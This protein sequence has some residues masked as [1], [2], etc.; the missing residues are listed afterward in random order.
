MCKCV[1]I[2]DYLGLHISPSSELARSPESLIGEPMPKTDGTVHYEHH[3]FHK[4]RM[5][6]RSR[7]RVLLELH[8]RLPNCKLP[9]PLKS[10]DLSLEEHLELC[11]AVGP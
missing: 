11:K 5:S 6:P 2:G 7:V 9:A 8:G 3:S 4:T 1:D 10:F